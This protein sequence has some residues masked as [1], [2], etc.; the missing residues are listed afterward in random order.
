MIYLLDTNIWL[1]RLLGQDRSEEVAQLLATVPKAQLAISHFSL[2][3]IG[4][5]L[6]R[7]KRRDT[8]REFT[9]DLFINGA[10]LLV[11]IQPAAF[12]QIVVAM[13]S[14]KLDFDDAYQ[15]V[16]VQQ[17]RAELVSFD[18][19]FDHTN[20]RRLIPHDVLERF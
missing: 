4:V 9:R 3:S 13:E 5:I 17:T 11:T 14:H 2:H 8:L 20:L 6:G 7:S 16:S 12:D 15:Y 19:D 18:T 10:V 1:E